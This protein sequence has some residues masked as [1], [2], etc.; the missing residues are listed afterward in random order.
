MEAIQVH[1]LERFRRLFVLILAAALFVLR[2]P[3]LWAP[4]LVHWLRQLSSAVVATAMDR[5]GPYLLRDGIQRVLSCLSLLRHCAKAP[6][7]LDLL[8]ERARDP[9]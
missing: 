1:K 2:L 7:P 8:P 5:E 4:A 6:P 3:G 9:T